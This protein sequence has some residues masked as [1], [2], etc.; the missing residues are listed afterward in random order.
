MLS[1]SGI[2]IATSESKEGSIWFNSSQLLLIF[3]A[4]MH[5]DYPRGC[6]WTVVVIKLEED[7]SLMPYLAVNT[8]EKAGNKRDICIA[9]F[10]TSKVVVWVTRTQDAR[11]TVLEGKSACD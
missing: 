5:T 1:L 4:M 11:D 7:F 3:F 6:F 10:Y 9:Q 2:S 8:E